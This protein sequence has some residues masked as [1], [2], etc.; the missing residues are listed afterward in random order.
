MRARYDAGRTRP[1]RACLGY[2]D[3]S[4]LA[5]NYTEIPVVNP[6]PKLYLCT[7]MLRV[8]RLSVVIQRSSHAIRLNVTNFAFCCSLLCTDHNEV[9]KAG[10]LV[11]GASTRISKNY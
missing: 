8:P 7:G 11:I 5:S 4:V 1:A 2:L 6:D 3:P 9:R 10:S